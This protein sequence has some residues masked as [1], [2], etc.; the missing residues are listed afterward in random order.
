MKPRLEFTVVSALAA[1]LLQIAAFVSLA[2]VWWGLDAGDSLRR[3][4]I[5]L[6][7]SMLAAGV[8]SRSWYIHKL[9]ITTST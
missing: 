7:A 5:W 1:G 8:P 9:R 4:L 2:A 6:P 3:T